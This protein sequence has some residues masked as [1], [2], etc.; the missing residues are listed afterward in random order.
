[1]IAVIFQFRRKPSR[2]LSSIDSHK[3]S[4]NKIT[5]PDCIEVAAFTQITEV[6]HGAKIYANLGVHTTTIV[7]RRKESFTEL[8]W[9]YILSYSPHC[10][11]VFFMLYLYRA[12]HNTINGR[13]GHWTYIDLYSLYNG[14]TEYLYRDTYIE[15]YLHICTGAIVLWVVE[16]LRETLLRVL[17]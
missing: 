10:L 2:G 6:R 16:S 8:N 5:R 3:G 7:G 13:S 4:T 9:I 14:S 15:R 17:L 12:Q 11:T 1:M